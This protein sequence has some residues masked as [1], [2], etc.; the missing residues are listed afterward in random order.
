MP[1]IPRNLLNKLSSKY[2]LGVENAQFPAIVA[3]PGNPGIVSELSFSEIFN[4]E[5]MF[6]WDGCLGRN[7]F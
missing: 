7:T 2:P 5:T 4:P 3:I 1:V 6:I